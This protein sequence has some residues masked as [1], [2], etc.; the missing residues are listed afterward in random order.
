M[1]EL[2]NVCSGYGKKQILTDISAEFKE[3]EFTGI[4][5]PNGCGKST[6]LKT[7]MGFLPCIQGEITVNGQ[8]IAKMSPQTVAKNLAYLAQSRAVP[9]MTVAQLVLHGRF[10]HLNY[11][12]IYG[13]KDKNIAVSAMKKMDIYHLADEPL[14]KISGGMRQKAYIAMAL[15]QDAPFLLP[16]E[17]TTYLDIANQFQLM[18]IFKN[19]AAEGKG[20]IAVMH[21][22]GTAMKFSDKIAVMNEGRLLISA[23]PDEIYESKIIEKVFGIRLKKTETDGKISYFCEKQDG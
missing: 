9:E 19:L 10:A 1:L 23:T 16:D 22:I 4:I 14:S 2:K 6:L 18:E 8:S 20:V 17:P 11:P 13:Q 7:V 3:G 15:A 21:D 5:G 12:R